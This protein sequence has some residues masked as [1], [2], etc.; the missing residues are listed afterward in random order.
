MSL[1]LL[2]CPQSWVIFIRADSFLSRNLHLQWKITRAMDER[3]PPPN[4]SLKALVWKNNI[5]KGSG[6]GSGGGIVCKWN[7]H[8]KKK[9]PGSVLAFQTA[10]S[11]K[12]FAECGTWSRASDKLAA[13]LGSAHSHRKSTSSNP[14]HGDAR[15]SNSS[16]QIAVAAYKTKYFLSERFL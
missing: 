7:F 13:P 9:L 14:P 5:K 12:K 10:L 4:D 3:L 2:S 15:N 6:G 1:R 11:E 16:K 8:K